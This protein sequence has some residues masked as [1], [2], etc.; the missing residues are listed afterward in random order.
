M[1]QTDPPNRPA[2]MS[3]NGNMP[4]P[5]ASMT[6]QIHLPEIPPSPPKI[7][8]AGH[9]LPASSPPRLRQRSRGEGARSRLGPPVHLEQVLLLSHECLHILAQH[10]IYILYTERIKQVYK[11][12]A[13]GEGKVARKG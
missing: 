1:R 2:K 11:Y 5:P 9:G 3:C 6:R 10:D 12:I 7:P 8:Q 13:L 4:D